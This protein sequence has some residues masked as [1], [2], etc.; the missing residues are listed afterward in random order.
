VLALMG[1]LEGTKCLKGRSD[2][3]VSVTTVTKGGA[4]IAAGGNV[5]PIPPVLSVVL[6]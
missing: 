2:P 1:F 6:E 4:M 3:L 5:R